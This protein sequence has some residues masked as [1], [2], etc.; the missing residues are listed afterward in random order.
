MFFHRNQLQN[1][2]GELLF[3]QPGAEIR[4]GSFPC[5][6]LGR[7]PHRSIKNR[8]THTTGQLSV[9]HAEVKESTPGPPKPCLCKVFGGIGGISG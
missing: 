5:G 8:K 4:S 2:D 7:G 9:S 3:H 6:D 1:R